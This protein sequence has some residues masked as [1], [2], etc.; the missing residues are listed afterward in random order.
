MSEAHAAPIHALTQG[1][2]QFSHFDMSLLQK[3][4]RS[5][6]GILDW[7]RL[8]VPMMPFLGP[9]LRWALVSAQE[10][11]DR[12]HDPFLRRAI[13]EFFGWPQIPMMAG[14]SLLGA[15]HTQN[16]GVPVGASLAFAR[17]IQ[18][19]YLD[20]GGEI[21][22]RAQMEKTLV[23]KDERG[24]SRAVGVRLVAEIVIQFLESKYPGLRSQIEMVDVAT[25]LSFERYT[26]NCKG[27]SSGW[28]LTKQTM[29]MNLTG[30]SKT[31]PGLH[32]FHMAGQWVEPG[33]MAPVVAMSGRNVVQMICH[34][35]G[36]PFVVST[37]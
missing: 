28:L 29:M 3:K 31:L 12:F 34:D 37:P 1:I 32:N 11:A 24:R 30:V 26:G 5:L 9:L 17:S 23:E 4:P 33:G 22:Y 18:K 21:L 2:R 35:D 15:M 25:P 19:R 20:V 7:A 27:A 6:M 10:F 8:G 36:W 13:P 16:A 14:L